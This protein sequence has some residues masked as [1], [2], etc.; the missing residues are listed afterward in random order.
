MLII[1]KIN[2]G[3]ARTL[4]LL[5]LFCKIIL[6]LKYVKCTSKKCWFEETFIGQ[7]QNEIRMDYSPI[8]KIGIHESILMIDI[9]SDK[10][11][12]FSLSET[13]IDKCEGR[14]NWKF[15]TFYPLEI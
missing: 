12:T 7:I 6:K 8:H 3:Y 2:V 14:V 4:L 1:G 10:G 9:F 15:T 11:R 13:P 5:L